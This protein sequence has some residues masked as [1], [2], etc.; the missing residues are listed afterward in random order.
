MSSCFI[1]ISGILPP[2]ISTKYTYYTYHLRSNKMLSTHSVLK[3]NSTVFI[4]NSCGFHNVMN[5]TSAP[6]A[7]HGRSWHT[8][9]VTRDRHKFILKYYLTKKGSTLPIINL[10]S[11][12]WGK[13]TLEIDINYANGAHVK[14]ITLWN[15]KIQQTS[16]M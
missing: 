5:F 3:T 14:S 11:F 8:G 1:T 10:F 6:L 13:T 7:W 4:K 2:L 12:S 15:R 9:S 16:L